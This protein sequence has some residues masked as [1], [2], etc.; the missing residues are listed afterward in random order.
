[1]KRLAVFSAVLMF[2]V[3]SAQAQYTRQQMRDSL[4]QAADSLKWYPNSV[5]L[6]L[7]KASWNM[8][9]EQYD[10]AKEEY[11]RILEQQPDNL[12]AL[13][14][15]A[16]TNRQLHRNAFARLD[17]Q[18][19]LT[20]IPNHFEARLGLALLS[21]EEQHLPQALDEVNILVQQHP[22]SA[23]AYAARADIERDMKLMSLAEFDYSEAIRLEP[24][25]T[26]YIVNLIDIYIRQHNQEKALQELRR[27]Q[28]MGVARKS[29]QPLYD[30]LK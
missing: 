8:Q 7:K 25:N 9:L 28:Q 15:R 12:A 16:Y 22:D 23:I 18:H 1:M 11:D 24:H 29:L 21:Q 19:L 14:F 27:L 17:Y 26:D 2:C 20:L 6:R 13:F 10:R 5:D 30:R 3:F 4:K